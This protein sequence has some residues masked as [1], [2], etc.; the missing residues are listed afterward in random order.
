MGKARTGQPLAPDLPLPLPEFRHEI[1]AETIRQLLAAVQATPPTAENVRRL[2]ERLQDLFSLLTD[3]DGKVVKRGTETFYGNGGPGRMIE[4][5][6]YSRATKIQLRK[7]SDALYH[8][9]WFWFVS[10]PDEASD[11]LTD[12]LRV[13]DPEEESWS[14]D[15][16]DALQP[17]VKRLLRY[18]RNRERAEVNEDLCEQV[19]CKAPEKVTSNAISKTLHDANQFLLKRAERRALRK[20]RGELFIVWD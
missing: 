9:A 13:I 18:M 12:T 4:L 6:G 20:P 2:C 15:D 5:S 1:V 8:P 16:W 17:R 19:W 11:L 14:G 3:S 10:H 7:L